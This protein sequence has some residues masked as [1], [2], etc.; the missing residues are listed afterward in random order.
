MPAAEAQRSGT[1]VITS[2]HSSMAEFTCDSDLLVNPDNARDIS[3]AIVKLSQRSYKSE[4]TGGRMGENASR[5]TW[6]ASA[7]AHLDAYR[8]AADGD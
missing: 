7:L 4:H 5:L 3:D 2:Q 8:R 6:R 1:A